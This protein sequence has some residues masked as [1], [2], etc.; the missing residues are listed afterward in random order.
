MEGSERALLAALWMRD[1]GSSE[2]AGQPRRKLIWVFAVAVV[3]VVMLR[4]VMG[5]W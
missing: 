1:A 4:V 5:V 3:L 2:G